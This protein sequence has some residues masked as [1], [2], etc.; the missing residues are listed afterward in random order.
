MFRRPSMKSEI[1]LHVLRPGLVEVRKGP[2]C[3]GLAEKQ[4]K[5]K[6]WILSPNIRGI[7]EEVMKRLPK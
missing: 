3:A 4:D 2:K 1:T 6:G 5:G 7:S